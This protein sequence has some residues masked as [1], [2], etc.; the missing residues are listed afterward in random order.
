MS[1][2]IQALKKAAARNEALFKSN[3]VI[4]V[5]SIHEVG[6]MLNMSKYVRSPKKDV[7]KVEVLHY[8]TWETIEACYDLNQVLRVAEESLIS[9]LRAA[10]GRRKRDGE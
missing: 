10:T 1:D 6:L 7:D 9:V 4:A 8:T 3:Q 5:W 2:I